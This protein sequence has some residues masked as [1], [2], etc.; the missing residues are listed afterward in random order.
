MEEFIERSTNQL[1]N[2]KKGIFNY[3]TS[4][5]FITKQTT[6]EDPE[7]I[8]LEL[9]KCLLPGLNTNKKIHEKEEKAKFIDD[10]INQLANIKTNNNIGID[11]SD[12]LLSIDNNNNNNKTNKNDIENLHKKAPTNF[13]FEKKIKPHNYDSAFPSFENYELEKRKKNYEVL[14]HHY[15]NIILKGNRLC[16]CNKSKHP[17]VGNCLNCGKIMCLQEG[18][19]KCI[20]C[21]TDIIS[22]KKSE[23]S[24]ML[25][26]QSDDKFNNAIT[27]KDKLLKFQKNFYSK[28]Q[29]IDDYTDWFEVANNSWIDETQRAFAKEK[30]EILQKNREDPEWNYVIN[31]LTG[32]I[33]QEYEHIDENKE[34]E[35]I[36]NIFINMYKENNDKTNNN[37]QSLINN[38]PIVCK[39]TDENSI[40]TFIYENKDKARKFVNI[41]N[42]LGSI[43]E[44][45]NKSI[46]KSTIV[47][48][49]NYMNTLCN[50]YLNKLRNLFLKN[51]N[52]YA[53]E[54]NY[55][56]INATEID[57]FTSE[58]DN[59]ILNEDKGVCLSMHQPWA[60]LLVYG[61]KRLEGRDWESNYRGKLWI[62]AA[63][64]KPERSTIELV[65]DEC[66][67]LYDVCNYKGR[68]CFPKSYPTSCLIGC[69]DMVDC[70]KLENIKKIYPK[71][72]LENNSSKY[73]FVCKN[74][75]ALDIPVK[76]PGDNKLFNLDQ[77]LVE[78]LN[79]SN[80]TKIN[81]VNTLWWPFENIINKDDKKFFNLNCLESIYKYISKKANY[82]PSNNAILNKGYTKKN[83]NN[84]YNNKDILSKS[85]KKNNNNNKSNNLISNYSTS[86]HELTDI[87]NENIYLIQDASNEYINNNIINAIFS[88]LNTIKSKLEFTT[89]NKNPPYYL[90]YSYYLNL[91]MDI[92]NSE[93]TDI[94]LN[95]SNDIINN[96][97]KVNNISINYNLRNIR[98]EVF[99]QFSSQNYLE[100]NSDTIEIKV[101]FGNSIY[102]Q[103]DSIKDENTNLNVNN[104]VSKKNNLGCIACNYSVLL[105]NLNNK[106]SNKSIYSI[107]HILYDYNNNAEINEDLIQGSLVLTIILSKN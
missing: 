18:D 6:K 24:K 106:F 16:N 10:F 76:M 100:I 79:D 62:H 3:A 1:Y 41:N 78:R 72:F 61:F 54:R 80:N 63:S 55:K 21:G 31:C 50:N 52:I 17:F 91:S 45:S 15:K 30:E 23:I 95:L 104:I 96:Y 29:I 58:A 59:Y 27:H 39:I 51:S 65:E 94:L 88:H 20:V 67:V 57:P 103:L 64:K 70:I 68:P 86:F 13:K 102:Y 97:K 26:Q 7:K 5:E 9:N 90:Q 60:S 25:N 12:K 73:M 105:F 74:P 4:K 93:Y 75:R 77:F 37:T 92:L 101:V 11:K 85:K 42:K 81:K 56:S 28:L 46:V 71:E 34:R 107:P 49:N 84:N 19:E 83:N 36:A 47:N 69:V 98:Y 8:R 44:N 66:K 33:K 40:N 87:N 22:N 43:L 38:K 48:N 99:N 35:D 89:N 2:W 53:S 82:D 32:E 14:P